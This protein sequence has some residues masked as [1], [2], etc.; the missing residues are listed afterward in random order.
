MNRVTYIECN[1]FSSQN[2]LAV[3]IEMSFTH[4]L[5][6]FRFKTTTAKFLMKGYILRLTRDFFQAVQDINGQF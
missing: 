6:F 3:I 2:S 5:I 4:L 1:I